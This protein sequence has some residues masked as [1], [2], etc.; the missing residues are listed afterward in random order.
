MRLGK[1]LATG[2][3]EEVAREETTAPE[4]ALEL[5]GNVEESETSVPDGVPAGR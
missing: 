3:A 4:D 1:A 5:P 2:V